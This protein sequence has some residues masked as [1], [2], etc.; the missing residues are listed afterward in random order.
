MYYTSD[1]AD[2]L[3][4]FRLMGMIVE[5]R[6]II[7]HELSLKA[8]QTNGK[9][10]E[11]TLER[12]RPLQERDIPT[13]VDGERPHHGSVMNAGNCNGKAGDDR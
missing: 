2:P 3:V 9:I 4:A 7:D 11:N 8:A 6:H 5:K 12:R 10:D 13:E 1:S